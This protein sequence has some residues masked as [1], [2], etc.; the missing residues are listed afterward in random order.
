MIDIKD[1]SLMKKKTKHKKIYTFSILMGLMIV[2]SIL[3]VLAVTSSVFTKDTAKIADKAGT[4]T[5]YGTYTIEEHSWWDILQLWTKETVKEVTLTDNTDYCSN[6]CQFITTI[7]NTKE[8]ALVEDIRFYKVD[9][10]GRETLSEIN[11]YEISIK[12]GQKEVEV[13]DYKEVCKATLVN[14]SSITNCL[15]EPIGTHTVLEDVY[16][17]YNIGDIVPVGVYTIKVTGDIESRTTYDWQIQVNGIW[18]TEWAIW[19]AALNTSLLGY[20]QLDETTGNILIDS[21]GKKNGSTNALQGVTGKI[22][23]AL[24]STGSKKTNV[25]FYELDGYDSMSINLWVKTN[26]SCTGECP[27]L[28][29]EEGASYGSKLIQLRGGSVTGEFGNGAGS[30]VVTHGGYISDNNW[31]M[32]TWIHGNYA[33]SNISVDGV[34]KDSTS[35]EGWG[36]AL[37]MFYLMSRGISAEYTSGTIDE[38]G[39]WN[40]S[41][42]AS[43]ITDLYN[44]GLG[45]PFNG[46]GLGAYSLVTPANGYL[47]ANPIVTFNCSA[48]MTGITVVN[49]SLWTNLSGTWALNTTDYYYVQDN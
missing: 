36:N 31:H 19:T 3:P 43:E 42:S 14:S 16:E 26:G 22:N 9:N 2:L 32:I 45:L 34:L 24:N 6:D 39:I 41:L 1:L 30:T 13:I 23:Y 47:T 49:M 27:I 35:T 12:T 21:V 37:T 8:G 25:S 48:S 33:T 44:G 11:S 17:K 29:I 46:V 18:T 38:V 20:Y 28:A 4:T 10:K 5:N 40:R 15:S 7:N